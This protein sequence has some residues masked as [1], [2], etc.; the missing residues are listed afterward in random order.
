MSKSQALSQR[1]AFPHVFGGAIS[2]W[3]GP[4]LVLLWLGRVVARKAFWFTSRGS[5]VVHFRPDWLP[6]N[7]QEPRQDGASFEVLQSPAPV[8]AS[9]RR[10]SSGV[11]QR[12]PA[13]S[14]GVPRGPASSAASLKSHPP[15]PVYMYTIF[16]YICIHIYIYIRIPSMSIR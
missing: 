9:V 13:S 2:P 14:L 3:R 5:E 12:R 4:L 15:R 1:A 11:R 6:A 7:G 8:P 16:M 10:E